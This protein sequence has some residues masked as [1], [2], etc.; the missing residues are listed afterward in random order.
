MTK[1][2]TCIQEAILAEDNEVRGRTNVA[3]AKL[4]AALKNDMD[5]AKSI[6]QVLLLVCVCIY[7]CVCVCVT[8]IHR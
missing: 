8:R 1:K 2:K 4:E 6:I 7:M 5:L 3:K